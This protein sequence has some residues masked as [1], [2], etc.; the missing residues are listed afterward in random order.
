MQR[1]KMIPYVLGADSGGTKYLVR[2]AAL[3]G[4]VLA[5]YRG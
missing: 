2:A 1:E 4:T 5:E 3:D